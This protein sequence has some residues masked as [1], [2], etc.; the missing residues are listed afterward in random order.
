MDDHA[1][2]APP[3]RLPAGWVGLAGFLMGAADAVPGVSGGTIALI[4]GIYQRLLDAISAVLRPPWTWADP[5]VRREMGRAI[6]FLVPLVGGLLVAYWLVTRLLVGPKDAPGLMRQA[7]TAPYCFAFFFGL[8][9]LSLAEP[10]RRIRERRAAIYVAVVLGAISAWFFVGLPHTQQA[11]QDWM[12]AVG[13]ALAVAVMLLPGISGSLLLVILGQYTTITGAIHD[14]EVGKLLIV[15]LGVV[16][17]VACFVPLLRWLLKHKHDLTL[18]ILTG[19]MA[20]SLRALWPWKTHYDI[21][22]GELENLGIGEGVLGCLAAALVGALCVMGLRAVEGRLH[23]RS[24]R[25][26]TT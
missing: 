4:V 22:R 9:L 18:A 2:D 21:K 15:A 10:W 17:G 7:E 11:P 20:G 13:A 1:P 3:N 23:A 6:R 24:K 5:P 26:E 8:V 19:L 16:L 12:L 14:K 25:D